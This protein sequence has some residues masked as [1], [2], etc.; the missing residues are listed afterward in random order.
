MRVIC[1]RGHIEV[2]TNDLATP[3]RVFEE[4]RPEEGISVKLENL[5]IDGLAAEYEEFLDALE[6]KPRN[7]LRVEDART[8]VA[9]AEAVVHAADSRREVAL[10]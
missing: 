6:G 5:L 3:I 10:L 8:A 9:C 4:G 7:R 2:N 1:E